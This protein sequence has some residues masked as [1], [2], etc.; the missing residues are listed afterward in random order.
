M[1]INSWIDEE[2]GILLNHKK[3]QIMLFAA[4]WNDLEIIILSEVGPI[5]KDIIW[6]HL[7]VESKKW[8]KW[9]YLQNK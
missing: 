8:Y 6:Y 3:N 1:S 5:E 2:N 7:L 4:A 9:A